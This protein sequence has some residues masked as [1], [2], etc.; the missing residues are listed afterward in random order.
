MALKHRIARLERA[1]PTA[2]GPPAAVFVTYPIVEVVENGNRVEKLGEGIP[3]PPG[4]MIQ[5]GMR[6]KVYIGIDEEDEPGWDIRKRLYEE[7][8]QTGPG[9]RTGGRVEHP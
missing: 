2:P 1:L 6:Y 4:S 8:A 3:W 7:A 5:P 9:K